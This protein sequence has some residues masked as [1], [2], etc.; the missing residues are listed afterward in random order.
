M[1]EIPM[2]SNGQSNPPPQ[3]EGYNLYPNNQSQR[4]NQV[5]NIIPQYNPHFNPV[6]VYPPQQEGNYIYADSSSQ[7]IYE[8]INSKNQN[9]SSNPFNINPPPQSEDEKVYDEINSRQSFCQTI[10]AIHPSNT[11][12]N[13]VDV[14]GKIKGIAF[15]DQFKIAITPEFQKDINIDDRIETISKSWIRINQMKEFGKF[16]ETFVSCIDQLLNKGTFIGWKKSRGDGNCYYRAVIS[17]YFELIHKPYYPV[18]YLMN[19]KTILENCIYKRKQQFSQDEYL[20]ACESILSYVNYSIEYKKSYPVEIFIKALEWL[21]KED[22]DLALVR[23]ARM[24]TYFALQDEKVNNQFQEFGLDINWYEMS[25][26]LMGEEAEGFMLVFLP[27]GL[28]CQVIQYNIFDKLQVENFP[29]GDNFNI[30]IPIV[31]RSGHYDILYTIQEM[32]YEQYSFD[33]GEYHFHN[34]FLTDPVS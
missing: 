28:K 11:P 29:M 4:F 20:T 3:I 9:P 26:L 17:K 30:K 25:I 7:Q 31:R 2:S 5:P 12:Y 10:N 33:T 16:K 23:T 1:N 15:K 27:L 6:N 32:E 19:F 8:S 13:P 18:S 14:F 24:I 22:I 34:T 21:L